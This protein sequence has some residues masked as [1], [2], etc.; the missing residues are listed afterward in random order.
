MTIIHLYLYELKIF[1]D[2]LHSSLING[3]FNG[4]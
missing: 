4:Q 1:M 3:E 2:N